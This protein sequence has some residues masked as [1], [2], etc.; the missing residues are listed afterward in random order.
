GGRTGQRRRLQDHAGSDREYGPEN[1]GGGDFR[2][3]RER[4]ETARLYRPVQRVPLG[5]AAAVRGRGP[6]QV[7]DAEGGGE[8]RVRHLAGVFGG[9]LRQ[10]L[11]QIRADV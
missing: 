6:G 8:R 3:V 2:L 4:G 9:L 1:P 5:H 10:R 7:Q 11:Q